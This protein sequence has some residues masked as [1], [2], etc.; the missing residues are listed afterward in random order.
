[1]VKQNDARDQSLNEKPEP[2]PA[3]SKRR[4]ESLQDGPLRRETTVTLAIWKPLI[5]GVGDPIFRGLERDDAALY[6]NC[7]GMCSIVGAQLGENVRDVALD[8]C[9][10]DTE[11]VRDLFVGIPDC[12]Q[13]QNLNL[14]GAQFVFCSMLSELGGDIRRYSLS[15]GMHRMDSL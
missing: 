10:P 2:W 7:D 11:S 8:G 13:P 4:K 5:V 6:P 9:F 12:N 15:S 1:M 14:P 3:V